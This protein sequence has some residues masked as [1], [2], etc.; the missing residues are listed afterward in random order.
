MLHAKMPAVVSIHHMLLFI[1]ALAGITLRTKMFQYITCYCLSILGNRK[2][3][4]KC[5]S[6]HHMLLFIVV[7]FSEVRVRNTVSIHHMLLFIRVF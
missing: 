4:L 3:A 6:I 5:V 7:S 2:E 1:N